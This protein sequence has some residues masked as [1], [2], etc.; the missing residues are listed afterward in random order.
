[1]NVIQ[2]NS[3]IPKVEKQQMNFK[4]N[5]PRISFKADDNDSFV[6]TRQRGPVYSQPDI[7]NQAD[8]MVR[9]MNEQKKE[10]D[11]QKFKNNL[12]WGLGIGASLAVIA[13]AL[14]S[15][16]RGRGMSTE[17]MQDA[18]KEMQATF[19]RESKEMWRDIAKEIGLEE[20][21]LSDKLIQNSK[22]I[23][24][25]VEKSAILKLMK[26]DPIFSILLYGPPG[27]GK[28]TYASAIAK[29][30]PGS[31][32][33]FLD[34]GTMKDMWHGGSEKKINAMIDEIC[35]EADKLLKEYH[36]ELG[37][38]IGDDLVKEGNQKKIANAILEAKKA[39]KKIPE[40]KRVFVLADEIDSIMMVDESTGGKI[41]NDMLNEFK[42]GFTDKLGRHEN[43]T[44]FGCTNLPINPENAMI[45]NKKL[46]TAM[47]D[48][49]QL[50]IEVGCPDKDQLYKFTQKHFKDCDDI[51]YFDEKFIKGVMGEDKAINDAIQDLCELLAKPE[52]EFSF[53]KMKDGLLKQVPRDIAHKV[54]E[55]PMNLKDLITAVENQKK[56]FKIA[57]AEL[58]AYKNKYADLLK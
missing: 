15:L 25:C 38:V 24:N 12:S 1:M 21:I 58:E 43:V 31:K 35:S 52:R 13:L 10:R 55:S 4:G 17:T 7:L 34:V 44:V 54:E 6:R 26:S 3:S 30:F 42:K 29:K 49:F 33:A 22:A 56:N 14:L 23:E 27:T 37:K 28:T 8:P 20:M 45:G 51:P 18:T 57:D 53:R 41:S 47:L 16:R 39:G 46:D 32:L 9:V 36:T 2:K 50:K 19:A 48:R 40:Q 11:K 5:L